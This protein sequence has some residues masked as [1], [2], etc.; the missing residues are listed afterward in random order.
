MLAL[1]GGGHGLGGARGHARRARTPPRA[2]RRLQ[3]L[4][5]PIEARTEWPGTRH[6]TLALGRPR[7]S[8]PASAAQG[9]GPWIV[10][11]SA[12]NTAWAGPW[13]TSHT[14]NLTPDR[15]TGLGTW[16]K[17]SFIATFRTGRRLGS[18]RA[19]LPPMPVPSYQNF[20]VEELEAIFAYLQSIPKISNRVSDPT[21]PSP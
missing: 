21:P 5:H 9:L 12:T 7:V 4:P 15:D 20:T 17:E 18:G 1:R 6:V 11:A 8:E 10:S 19:L 16:S 2:H 3:R 13:G 14:S